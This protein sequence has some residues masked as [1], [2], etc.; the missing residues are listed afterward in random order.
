[1]C[2]Q[3]DGQSECHQHRSTERRR[4]GVVHGGN[5][6]I[7]RTTRQPD[8][9]GSGNR[10]T[11]SRTETLGRLP[12]R[13]TEIAFQRA[14]RSQRPR[15]RGGYGTQE[16]GRCRKQNRS[17]E[18]KFSQVEEVN[19]SPYNSKGCLLHIMGGSPYLNLSWPKKNSQKTNIHHHK[20]KSQWSP[21]LHLHTTEANS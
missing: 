8:R 2:H 4:H 9:R 3:E 20:S 6:G 13:R 7:C 21:L 10:Q 17:L 11:R 14:F 5:D 18:R 12:D 19:P 16:T 15:C 1:M